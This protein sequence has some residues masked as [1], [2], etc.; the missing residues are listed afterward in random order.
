MRGSFF[1]VMWF[2]C[3]HDIMAEAFHEALTASTEEMFD[4]YYGDFACFL[5]LL[6]DFLS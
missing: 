4:G 6:S 1:I 3:A 5:T 2:L